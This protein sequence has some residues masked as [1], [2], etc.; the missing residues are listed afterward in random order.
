MG[1]CFLRKGLWL[2]RDWLWSV[3]DPY[4][5][6]AQW[7]VMPR[8]FEA[9][10]PVNSLLW[11]RPRGRDVPS[12]WYLF[13]IR[14]RG[15]NPRVIGLLRSGV[16]GF[17]QARPMYPIRLRFRVVRLNRKRPLTLELQRVSEPMQI[18]RLWLLRLPAWDAWRRIQ[19]RLRRLD[20]YV[21][22][23]PAA[24]WQYYNQ[25]LN[26]QV[27][28]HALLTYRRWQIQIEAPVLNSLPELSDEM[29][30]LFV[31]QI[32]N[33]HRLFPV[34]PEQWVVVLRPGSVLNSWGLQAMASRL[35][36]LSGD[37]APLVLYGDEDQRSAE[38]LR[39]SPK[40]KPA[41]NCELFWSDPWYSCH[42][43]VAG[44]F[45]NEMLE[46]LHSFDWW[47]VQ[48]ALLDLA[49]RARQRGA[50]RILHLPFVVAHV[51]EFCPDK[52]A[53]SQRRQM[54]QSLGTKAPTLECTLYGHQWHW[55]CPAQ[56]LLSVI[57]PTRD[58]LSLLQACLHSIQH[59]SAGV[60][61]ELI[62]VDNG[63][64]EASTLAFLELFQQRP[65]QQVLRVD[66]PF[67]YSALNNTAATFARGS[68]LLLLNNDVEF[69]S[70]NW[71]K[72]LSANALRN[73]IGCVGAQL[74]YPDR[75]IQHGGVLLGI[76]GMASHAHQNC[77][78]D[79]PGYQGRLQM[80]QE[81]S[82]VT[83]ACLAISRE[84]WQQLGGLDEENLWVNYN[85]VDLCLRA[86]AAGLRNLYLPQVKAMHHESKS[87]G[88]PEG[89]AYRQ[90]RREWAVM[91]QRWGALLECDPA[92]SP[93]LTLED[94][95]FGLSYRQEPLALR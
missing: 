77:P 49:D 78:T 37:D 5:G 63:S 76:G 56:T 59:V 12:G 11:L 71:G 58:H 32:L 6:S 13:V 28:Q 82:A 62:V 88:R 84:N 16:W 26:S 85:D 42:W 46:E 50:A 94:E 72:E 8:G 61:L 65:H 67:N 14:H 25:L 86:G 60:D 3:T 95:R 2:R 81:F 18:C 75:T 47:T 44:R 92:Y 69:I 34:Q 35:Q 74:H 79:A 36:G 10:V 7:S 45:W 73:G 68:V 4:T 52:A 24:C 80:A 9:I 89:A 15:N 1:R 22:P 27:G 51:L 31:S 23:L 70:A 39:H 48:Y 17:A 83:A 40:F 30:C 19:R 57:I 33:G 66:G 21:P 41:W 93:W 43:V 38:G 91:E 90:W 29:A 53:V 87:R 54:R 64:V 55:S 20:Q